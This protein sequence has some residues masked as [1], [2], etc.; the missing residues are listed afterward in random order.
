MFD[1]TIEYYNLNAEAQ[2]LV[3]KYQ[4]FL[5]AGDISGGEDG[6]WF[7]RAVSEVMACAKA[8]ADKIK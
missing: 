3:G 2:Q 7:D 4:E 8:V 6:M 1:A 5:L